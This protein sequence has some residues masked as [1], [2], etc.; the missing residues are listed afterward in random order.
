MGVAL[1]AKHKNFTGLFGSYLTLE[2]H[3]VMNFEPLPV[4]SC[5]SGAHS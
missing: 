5:G 2:D 3:S 4:Q 1:V